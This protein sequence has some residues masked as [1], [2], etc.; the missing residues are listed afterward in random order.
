[1]ATRPQY[2]NFKE[3]CPQSLAERSLWVGMDFTSSGDP[4]ANLKFVPDYIKRRRNEIWHLK[5]IFKKDIG[6]HDALFLA[7][8]NLRLVPYMRRYRS[9]FYVDFSPSLMRSL[10][11]WYDHFHKHPIAQA[12]RESLAAWL[13]RSARGVLTMS[14]W[15][16]DG[17]KKG[18]RDC[19][20]PRPRSATRR[21]PTTMELHRPSRTKRRANQNPDGWR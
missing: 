5:Q 12:I 11:P 9:Y 6:K 17:I 10:S 8:W 15:S 16:A 20:R 1:M 4:I 3:A 19:E 18:L 7:S 2:L 21:K 13:P 14:Q